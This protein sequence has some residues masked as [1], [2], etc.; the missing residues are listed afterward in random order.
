[1]ATTC[2]SRLKLSQSNVV[3]QSYLPDAIADSHHH[4]WDLSGS[5]R[6]P[7]LQNEYNA[8]TFILGDYKPLCQNFMPDTLQACWG[9]LPVTSTVHVE[10]EC[11]RDQALQET[12]WLSHIARSKELPHAIIGYVDLLAP[13]CA[14]QLDAHMRHPLFRGVRFKPATSRQADQSIKNTPGSLQDPRWDAGLQEL[15]QRNLI[16][17]LR[18]PFWHLLEAADVLSRHPHTRVVIEH[19]GLPWDRSA[20]GLQQWRAGMQ[21]LADLP[22]GVMVK[23]SE[24]GLRGEPWRIEDN[25]IIVRDLVAMF[26]PSRCMFGSN[27]PVASLRIGYVDLVRAMADILSP[28]DGT[29]RQR[30]WHDNTVQFYSIALNKRNRRD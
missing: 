27:F 24:L 5:I 25:R 4:F 15:T 18:V 12:A 22:N 17:D 30:I 8:S 16:W 14:A 9:G 26:G 29:A 10:A 13:D 11:A 7:W 28:F 2:S 20:H 23:L 19:A 3:A 21:A 6:Y 1:M